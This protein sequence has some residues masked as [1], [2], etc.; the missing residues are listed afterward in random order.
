MTHG[1]ERGWRPRTPVERALAGVVVVLA[2]GRA[3][4]MAV[5]WPSPAALPVGAEVPAELVAAEV[6]AVTVSEA[7]ED[8]LLEEVGG[9]S[10]LLVVTARRGAGSA[11]VLTFT[12]PT[13]SIGGSNS[14][15][16]GQTATR[17]ASATPPTG[18]PRDC[19]DMARNALARADAEGFRRAM[20][21]RCIALA[22]G[23]AER[24]SISLE[25][26]SCARV[27]TIS[28]S[29]TTPASAAAD[30]WFTARQSR[31]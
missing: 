10:E 30:P 31:P 12:A 6:L 23:E 8:P 25:A 29:S 7:E 9:L 28:L 3:L 20:A 4:G 26:G 16:F 2:L 22:R 18:A 24:V 17:L 5:L 15:W 11:Q 13:A 19:A 21:P 1:D 14:L 27:T